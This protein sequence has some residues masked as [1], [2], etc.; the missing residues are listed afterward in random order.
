LGNGKCC[1]DLFVKIKVR[2][3]AIIWKLCTTTYLE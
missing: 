2:K 1:N 3:I